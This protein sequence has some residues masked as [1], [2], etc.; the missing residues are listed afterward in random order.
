MGK[1]TL[2]GGIYFEYGFLG[3]RKHLQST[4]NMNAVSNE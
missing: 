2:L 3:L 1:A 4:I